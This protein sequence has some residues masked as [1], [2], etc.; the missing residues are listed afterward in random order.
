MEELK[1]SKQVAS[2][3]LNQLVERQVI[4]A[5]GK[6][7]RTYVYAAEE[8]ISLLSRRFGSDA[9]EALA[10]GYQAIQKGPRPGSFPKEA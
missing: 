10:A 5:R 9:E 4:R 8:L 1:L 7:G 2:T 3:A 6:V